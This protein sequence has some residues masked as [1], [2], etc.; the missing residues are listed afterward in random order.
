[1]ER[2]RAEMD[3]IGRDLEAPEHDMSRGHGSHVTSLAPEMVKSVRSTLLVL[4]A[5][6]AFILL[7]ACINVTNLLLA[8]AAG[9]RREMALRA[10]IGAGRASLMR[11]VIVEATVLALRVVRSACSSLVGRSTAGHADA[12]GAAT[13]RIAVFSL[14]ILLFTAGACLITGLLAGVLPAWQLVHDAPADTA[15]GRR[16]QPGRP[17]RTLRFGLVV[18]E[19][20]FTSLLLVGAGLTLRSFQ[21]VLIEPAGIETDNRLTFNVRLP[22]ARYNTAEAYNR[23][24]G[25]LERRLAA[26]A[27]VKRVGATSALPLTG[28]DR[29]NGIAIDGIERGPEDGP[30]RAHPRTVTPGYME[31]AGVGIKEGRGF[32]D[33]DRTGPK[34]TI[35]NETMARRYW[36][37][38]PALGGR[39]RFTQDQESGGR[40]SA[41]FTT[42]STGVSMCR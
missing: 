5:A 6:V 28:A 26:E 38:A 37:G 3:Q 34:V 33:A 21:Q 17:R 10:A 42:S 32:T 35:I 13:R 7:I 22:R 15:E 41:S 20:A 40:S 11:Q 2:A 39:V 31:A 25:D 12:G 18:A 24:F 36:R 19:V 14:P 30:T 16:P 27:S 29:R 1:M 9:R 23:F 8:R 4:M